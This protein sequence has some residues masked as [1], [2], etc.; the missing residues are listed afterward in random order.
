MAQ[1][2][3]NIVKEADDTNMVVMENVEYATGLV[4]VPDVTEKEITK[5]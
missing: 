2:C 3:V 1:V 5:L 4:G